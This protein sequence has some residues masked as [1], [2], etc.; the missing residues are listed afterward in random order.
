MLG[1]LISH[2]SNSVIDVDLLPGTGS[3]I[4]FS[5]CVMSCINRSHEYLDVDVDTSRALATRDVFDVIISY[6]V[7]HHP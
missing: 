7:L 3:G 2:L 4:E 5:R 1:W 6:S